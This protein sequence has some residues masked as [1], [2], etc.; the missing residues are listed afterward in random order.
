M[1]V[2]PQS[3]QEAE[4]YVP[5]SKLAQMG[6]CQ[7]QIVRN[8]HHGE[9]VTKEQEA[10]RADGIRAHQRMDVQARRHHNAPGRTR[11]GPCFIASAVYGQ[12][13]PRTWE[14][15]GFRD[16][17]LRRSW[18]GRLLVSWYYRVS[19]VLA[20]HLHRHR[21][22]RRPVRWGV[23]VVRW[24]IRRVGQGGEGGL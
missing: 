2:K 6:Y 5:V 15:R 3:G 23:D 7:V 14:L 1:S 21:A 17:V 4:G 12:N 10:A 9:I 11:P 16:R 22:M 13:D 19:P 24:T 18:P 8:L 20:R